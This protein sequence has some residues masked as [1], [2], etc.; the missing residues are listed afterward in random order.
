MPVAIA[1]PRT[2]SRLQ[3]FVT[4]D[5][6][7]LLRPRPGEGYNTMLRGDCSQIRWSR[8]FM[9]VTALQ[10]RLRSRVRRSITGARNR[11]RRVVLP[12]QTLTRLLPVFIV[13]TAQFLQFYTGQP[14]DLA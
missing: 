7:S 14:Q 9:I 5:S 2:V 1:P 8:P 11:Q 10:C 4:T 13:G 3:L 6:E 12:E